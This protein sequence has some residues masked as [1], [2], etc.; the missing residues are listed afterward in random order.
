MTPFGAHP[1]DVELDC[2]H[3]G[4]ATPHAFQATTIVDGASCPQERHSFR[5]LLCASMLAVDGAD[6]PDYGAD[7]LGWICARRAPS[8][9]ASETVRPPAFLEASP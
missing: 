7:E 3:C 4:K 8:P 9:L 1:H 6:C 2:P 5:C